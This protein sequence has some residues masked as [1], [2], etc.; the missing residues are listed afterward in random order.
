MGVLFSVA[1]LL[2]KRSTRLSRLWKATS[3]ESE[4]ERCARLPSVQMEENSEF[5]SLSPS[6]IQSTGSVHG[7]ASPSELDSSS[8]HNSSEAQDSPL[9]LFPSSDGN[10]VPDS[11]LLSSGGTPRT[12]Y[13]KTSSTEVNPPNRSASRSSF[14][15]VLP[16]STFPVVRNRK[17]QHK[18]LG[19][20]WQVSHS[21]LQCS[22]VY[23]HRE[24]LILCW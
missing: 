7:A 13:S 22:A 15:S 19:I 20:D 21:R 23:V 18:F 4:Q 24:R 8:S 6:L 10:S 9:M 12:N 14:S 2:L 11:V 3:F 5:A 17:L 1:P 16:T